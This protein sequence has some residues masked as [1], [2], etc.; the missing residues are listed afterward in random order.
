MSALHIRIRPATLGDEYEIV[1][2]VREL[3]EYERAA[4]LAVATPTHFRAAL[5]GDNPAVHALIAETDS[6][7]VAGFALWFLN[8]STWQGRHGI[9]LE[10]LYVRPQFRGQGMGHALLSELASICVENDFPRFEWAVLD[11]NEPARDVYQHIGAVPL[12]EW[13]PYRIS[14]SALQRLAARL[15]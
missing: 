13:V 5:F 15:P 10:D 11:W 6:G 2:M 8:F 12:T 1:A 14:G 4:D 3:A 7:D 9:H